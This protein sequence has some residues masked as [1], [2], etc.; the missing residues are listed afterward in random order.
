MGKLVYLRQWNEKKFQEEYIQFIKDVDF[1][2][3]SMLE[4]NLD[5]LEQHFEREINANNSR[6]N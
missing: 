4:M 5:E 6:K 2:I 1:M 3:E